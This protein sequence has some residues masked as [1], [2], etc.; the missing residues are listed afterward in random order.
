MLERRAGQADETEY[1]EELH[2]NS[3]QPHLTYQQLQPE[4]K[5]VTSAHYHPLYMLNGLY[6]VQ[7]TRERAFERLLSDCRVWKRQSIWCCHF[8]TYFFLFASHKKNKKN[9]TDVQVSSRKGSAKPQD[10][11]KDQ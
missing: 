1:A 3:H 8:L 5:H 11:V 7:L 9:T 2:R 10:L 6:L 4:L